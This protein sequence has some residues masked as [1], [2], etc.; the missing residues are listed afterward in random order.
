MLARRAVSKSFVDTIG[1]IAD[2]AVHIRPWNSL[3]CK[4]ASD[5]SWC[6]FWA[7]KIYYMQHFVWLDFDVVS[8]FTYKIQKQYRNRKEKN[9]IFCHFS[10]GE[11][12]NSL[13]IEQSCDYW[14]YDFE[15]WTVL[16]KEGNKT[17]ESII[18]I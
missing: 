1:L 4:N 18:K 6:L 14:F 17:C 2:R 8:I 9:S 11:S 12:I 13:Y 7:H 16:E 15:F 5:V 10:I 3:G